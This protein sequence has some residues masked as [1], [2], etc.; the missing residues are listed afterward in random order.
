MS[1]IATSSPETES[2][3]SQPTE[4][5]VIPVKVSTTDVQQ[6][7]G[8]VIISNEQFQE[9]LDHFGN[10]NR[11]QSRIANPGALGL[12]A[13]ALTTFILSVFNTGSYFIDI[14]L[15]GVVLPVALFYGGLAQFL[16]GM[17]EFKV[18]NTFG[19]T[20]F[21]SYGAFWMS[22]AGYVHIIL[23]KISQVANAKKATGLFLLAWFIFTIIM[24]VAASKTSKF[25]FILFTLLNITF[26][27]LIIGNLT[28]LTLVINIGGWFGI[29]TAFTAWYGSAAILINS[30]FN[31]SILPLGVFT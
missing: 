11:N 8:S 13:F 30:T 27:L 28:N 12:A 1:R 21:T 17:W 14:K 3:I 19:A 20:A 25:L 31:K 7:F 22:F 5:T 16:A 29:I 2:F 24:N 23:P 18:N 6:S 9:L 26:L 4:V 10:S 15:E